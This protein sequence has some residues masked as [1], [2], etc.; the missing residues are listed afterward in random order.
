L[1][2]YIDS[3]ISFLALRVG[4]LSP[5][6]YQACC[7]VVIVVGAFGTYCGPGKHLVRGSLTDTDE[8]LESLEDRRDL[9]RKQLL[10]LEVKLKEYPRVELGGQESTGVVQHDLVHIIDRASRQGTVRVEGVRAE[11]VG[12]SDRQAIRHRH[13]VMVTGNFAGISTFIR[14]ISEQGSPIVL[15]E[16]EVKSPEWSYPAQ[17]LQATLLLETAAVEG[18]ESRSDRHVD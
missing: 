11:G 16:V 15:I 17:P 5:V 3:L 4:R 7:V 18:D 8:A 2:K 12:V 6:Q 13:Q 1:E 14:D 10:E 9:H